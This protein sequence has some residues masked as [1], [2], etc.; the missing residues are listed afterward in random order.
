MIPT[1]IAALHMKGLREEQRTKSRALLQ[2]SAVRVKKLLDDGMEDTEAFVLLGDALRELQEP[3]A[4]WAYESAIRTAR[5]KP[6]TRQNALG[7][8]FAGRAWM[9]L[10][11]LQARAGRDAAAMEMFSQGM[12]ITPDD[13][14]LLNAAAWL[15]ATSA[16]SAVRNPQKAVEWARKAAEA[17]KEK[18][19]AYMSTLAE[20]YFASNQ[21]QAAQRAISVAIALEPDEPAYRAQAEKFENAAK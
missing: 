4:A 18:N 21:I 16:D 8:A 14:E 20:A 2:E 11:A 7:Q 10:G 6:A 15:A 5:G 17:T 9:G 13:P 3:R 12:L 1:L 19:A